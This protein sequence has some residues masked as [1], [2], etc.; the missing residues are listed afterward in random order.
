MALVD[1]VLKRRERP[2]RGRPNTLKVSAKNMPDYD[3]LGLKVA[4]T[5]DYVIARILV[6]NPDLY[7]DKRYDVLYNDGKVVQRTNSNIYVL[8]RVPFSIPTHIMPYIW[9]RLLTIVPVL[10]KSKI[11]VVPGFLWDMEKGELVFDD[12]TRRKV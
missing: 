4:F 10:D 6:L 7:Y 12:D 5:P 11:I 8:S 2:E 9:V 3:E 1:D